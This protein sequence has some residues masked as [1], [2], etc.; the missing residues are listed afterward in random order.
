MGR[1][2]V[3]AIAPNEAAQGRGPA[4]RRAMASGTRYARSAA[5]FR[6]KVDVVLVQTDD[7]NALAARARAK[8]APCPTP[9]SSWRRTAPWG[10]RRRT[11]PTS[12]PCSSFAERRPISRPWNRGSWRASN[13]AGRSRR[14]RSLRRGG[15]RRTSR[16]PARTRPSR[17]C[18]ASRRRPRRR[19]PTGSSCSQ[20]LRTHG[21]CSS[22]PRQGSSPSRPPPAPTRHRRPSGRGVGCRGH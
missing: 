22:L 7:A 17:A 19:S 4:T 20:R 3:A 8:P 2:L 13:P 6:G 1:G 16:S 11:P 21:R 15:R 12:T 10:S 14:R 9:H 18:L 5:R